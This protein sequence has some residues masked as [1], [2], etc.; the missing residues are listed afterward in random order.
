MRP[1]I[2]FLISLSITAAGAAGQNATGALSA[3]RLIPRSDAQRLAGIEAREGNLTP[4]RWHF[5]VHDPGAE[6]G[7][8]EYVIAG[9][10]IVAMRDL[11]QFAETLTAEDVVGGDSVKIDSDR[12]GRLA[13]QYARA[14]GA[15]VAT[16]NYQLKR[17]PGG[18]GANWTVTCMDAAG[19]RL[20]EVVCDAGKAA[21]LSHGGFPREP[22]PNK[23]RIV[24]AEERPRDRETELAEMQRRAALARTPLPRA[25]PTGAVPDEDPPRR[26][27]STLQRFFGLGR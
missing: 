26:S 8:R 18:G 1:P 16:V 22:A 7:V 9:G 17:A 4:E 25:T 6:N 2:L 12:V 21:V 23:P 19:R 24:R 11:S 5:L 3:L 20:G 13:Q 27:G 14:N 10:E 15:S